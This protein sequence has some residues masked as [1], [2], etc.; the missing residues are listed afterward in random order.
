MTNDK[1][2]K[3]RHDSFLFDKKCEWAEYGLRFR[4]P[5]CGLKRYLLGKDAKFYT[6]ERLGCKSCG[7]CRIEL[8][9]KLPYKRAVHLNNIRSRN[10]NVTTNTNNLIQK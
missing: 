5:S 4:C 7:Q 1:Y 8:K 3:V 2:K 6:G 10:T 9:G